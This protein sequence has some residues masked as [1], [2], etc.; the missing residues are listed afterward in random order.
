[1]G[2]YETGIGHHETEKGHYETEMDHYETVGTFVNINV[3]L[4]NKWVNRE[5]D[6]VAVKHELIICG[7]KRAI[8]KQE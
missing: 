2:N 3:S 8:T 5:Q 1:M 6:W 4:W 7:Q